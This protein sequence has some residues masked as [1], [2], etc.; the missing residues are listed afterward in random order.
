MESEDL[1]RNLAQSGAAAGRFELQRRLGLCL[2]GG[3]LASLMTMHLWLGIRPD[4]AAAAGVFA[5]WLKTIY[6]IALAV[7]AILLVVRLARPGA[8]S[9]AAQ[10]LIIA[11]PV[12]ILAVFAVA[13]FFR[14]GP[15][16]WRAAWLGASAGQCPFRILTLAF[17]VYAGA[18][19]AFRKFAPANLWLAGAAAGAAS[20]AV[21]AAIYALHCSE[22]S[23]SFVLSWY[24]LGI[25]MSSL[26]GALAGRLLLRW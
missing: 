25:L 12:L 24:T 22:M 9:D 16:D 19:W 20:G 10:F 23:P 4:L 18:I 26:A 7:F 2:F 14:A 3:A 17:P 21:G 5:F 8:R 6:A 15:A 11:A 13:E 1:I